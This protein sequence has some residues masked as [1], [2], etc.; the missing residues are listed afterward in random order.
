VAGRFGIHPALLD[1]AL[2]APLLT[3]AGTGPVRVPFAW[4][5][6]RLYAPGVPEVRVRVSPAGTDAVSV[7]L[8]DPSGRPVARVASL[9]TRELPPATGLDVVRHALLR[10]E[11]TAVD[12]PGRGQ[13][14]DPGR[15][16]LAGPDELDLRGSLPGLVDAAVSA[17]DTVVVTA[18]AP[19]GDADP[20]AGVHLLTGRVLR[21]VQDWQDDPRTAG[22]RLV[23]VTRDATA[24]EPD[25]A[26]AAVWGLVRTAQSELPG[27]VVLVDVDGRPE[28]LRLLPAAVATGEPQLSIHAGELTAPRLVPAP[29]EASQEAPQEAPQERPNGAPRAFGPDGTVLITGGPP[30]RH[31]VRCT[32][33][34]AH[35]TPGKPGA[36]CRGTARCAGGVGR[37]GADRGL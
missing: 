27:R 1:A 34:A 17:P 31:L 19:P 18:V 9:T 33:P 15:W 21:T 30:S 23:V 14:A 11:W 35:R 6:V 37:R 22:A 13:G 4:N 8:T 28:S 16:A 5:G 10:P 24:P 25:L 3:G 29:Q 7:T 36:R 12:L 20:P 32:T 26:G 2:H